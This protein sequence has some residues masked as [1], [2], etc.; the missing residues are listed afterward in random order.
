MGMVAAAGAK[1]RISF[2]E[3]WLLIPGPQDE[4]WK[5]KIPGTGASSWEEIIQ[6][7]S[8]ALW[9]L[10]LASKIGDE[11]FPT[12]RLPILFGHWLENRKDISVR[13]EGGKLIMSCEIHGSVDNRLKNLIQ[14]MLL[15]DAVLRV[16]GIRQ[17][18]KDNAVP[19]SHKVLDDPGSILNTKGNLRPGSSEIQKQVLIIVALR[20]SFMHGEKKPPKYE[21][22]M[23][24]FRDRWISSDHTIPYNLAV[25]ALACRE[26]WKNLAEIVDEHRSLE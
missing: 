11:Y 7:L 26:V 2:T 14:S 25:I 5:K 19:I 12:E 9:H 13:S 10:E 17:I 16:A 20:D 18:L 23:A 6:L 22:K 8:A 15:V 1:N 3:L 21:K 24:T 4:I